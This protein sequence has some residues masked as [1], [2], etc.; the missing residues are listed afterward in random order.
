MKKF[1]I[2]LFAALWPSL[3]MANLPIGI[4]MDVML[5]EF[6]NTANQTIL[7]AK[8]ATNNVVN[9]AA[10]NVINS[11]AQVRS[12]YE[13]ALNKTS[14]EL[15]IK[16]RE[17]FEELQVRISQV[18][19]GTEEE[20]N[21]LD[22]SLDNLAIYISDSIF[23]SDEPRVSRFLS[24]LTVA[25]SKVPSPISILFKG[26]NLNHP[27]NKLIVKID[28][29]IV[30]DPVTL[31]DD[32]IKFSLPRD[33]V[34]ENANTN[35][36]TK[37]RCELVLHGKWWVF[38]SKEKKYFYEVGVLPNNLAKAIIVVK[39]NRASSGRAIIIHGVLEVRPRFEFL[40]AT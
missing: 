13:S 22:N 20:Q 19:K 23:L 7:S 17:I 39:E 16:Q 40:V 11:V 33:V 32:E 10:Y 30:L 31:G 9:N 12:E 29:N 3:S 24:S 35:R 4:T 27:K 25:E 14:D 34:N 21:N 6:E 37:I 5:Q 38:F 8:N 15:T 26:K 28:N 36:V 18:F 1:L 2:F